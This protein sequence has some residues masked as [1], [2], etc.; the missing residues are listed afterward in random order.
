[1]IAILLVLVA[2]FSAGIGVL[3]GAA[4]SNRGTRAELSP[5][6]PAPTGSLFDREPPAIRALEPTPAPAPVAPDPPLIERAEASPATPEHRA[7]KPA[8]PSQSGVAALTAAP[9]Q[10]SPA[11]R[12]AA[13]PARAGSVDVAEPLT[14]PTPS[15][16]EL[17]AP[18]HAD[19]ADEVAKVPKRRRE[20]FLPEDER[21]T[22]DPLPRA[23]LPPGFID[24]ITGLPLAEAM[25]ADIELRATDFKTFTVVV[26]H[27]IRAMTTPGGMVNVSVTASFGEV[28]LR[29][30]ASVLRDALRLRD[31]VGRY[32]ERL[33]LLFL[34]RCKVEEVRIV[35]DRIRAQ[36]LLAQIGQPQWVDIA[37][38]AGPGQI[39]QSVDMPLRVAYADLVQR[40][41]QPAWFLEP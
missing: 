26:C 41:T 8:P 21:G 6:S 36:L 17:W 22:K 3:V 5:V 35:M 15:V 29:L 7:D 28:E 32:D 27:P 30:F 12:S 31:I 38:G 33:F 34:P 11:M 20:D 13:V 37:F 23:E 10:P 16:R 9:S 24:P 18:P 4:L 25:R 39:G 2:A 40:N 14:V 19:L 1:M